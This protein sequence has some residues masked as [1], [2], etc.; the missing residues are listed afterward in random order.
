MVIAGS[1]TMSLVFVSLYS[2]DHFAFCAECPNW[3]KWMLP[4]MT[5]DMGLLPGS[6]CWSTVWHYSAIIGSTEAY[7][8]PATFSQS[9][10][11]E[12]CP[13]SGGLQVNMMIIYVPCVQPRS[14]DVY[15]RCVTVCLCILL[16]TSHV[17]T[18]LCSTGLHIRQ[19]ISISSLAKCTLM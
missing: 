10:I 13:W 3:K 1:S 19:S 2:G 11:L 15:Q 5:R 18:V 12:T 7:W 6:D 17:L 14:A 16:V 4:L 9:D 8:C